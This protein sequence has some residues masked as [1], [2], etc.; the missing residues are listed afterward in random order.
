MTDWKKTAGFIGCGKMGG[1]LAA[2]AAKSGWTIYAADHHPDKLERLQ[3]ECGA[4][5]STT[6]EIART[7]RFLFFGVKP[8]GMERAAAETAPLLK[9]RG[10]ER[11]Y[12]AVTMAAG[13]PAAAVS[14]MLG[15]CPVI[16]IMPNTPAAVGEGVIVYC[17]APS[18]AAGGAGGIT[19][20]EEAAFLEVLKPAGTLVKL[21]EGRIDAASAVSGCGPA[22]V[23]LF[24]EALIQGAVRCGLP[25]E[26]AKRL[27]VQTV[28][29]TA[30][31]ALQTDRDPALL[32]GDVC[33]P[34]GSTI[35]GVAVLEARAVRSAVL[36]A[37]SAA[38]R[39]T[40]ELGTV[41]ALSAGLTSPGTK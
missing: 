8:Q 10:A 27:A 29:G 18:A 4:I 36:E 6:E 37:V 11:P 22:F 15:D 38:Y 1:T 33:S 14:R 41:P 3:K 12:L 13:L 7:C 28:Y 30:K 39:R 31:L 35:E 24:T 16:R 40:V 9:E 25:G 34:S 32:R 2:A 21:D 17:T 20:A 23:C 26:L 5:P 19:E